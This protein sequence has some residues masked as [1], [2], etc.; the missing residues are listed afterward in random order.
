MRIS[1]WSSDVCSSDLSD[2]GQRL[3]DPFSRD[4]RTIVADL[5]EAVAALGNYDIDAGRSLERDR[6]VTRTPYRVERILHIFADRVA[7]LDIHARRQ[8]LEDIGTDQKFRFLIRLGL[9]FAFVRHLSSLLHH[10][11]C[12]PVLD[13]KSTRLNSIP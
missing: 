11:K 8:G 4:A 12:S 7:R 6:P 1:D 3:P 2:R 5:N 9:G 13:R 10:R